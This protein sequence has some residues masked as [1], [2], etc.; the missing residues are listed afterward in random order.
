MVYD[1]SPAVDLLPEQAIGRARYMA[2]TPIRVAEPL[3]DGNERTYVLDCLES[4]WISSR[5]KYIEQF[6]DLVANFCSTQHAIATNN[7]T[8]ALHLALAALGIGPG[9]EVIVPTL[10]Y[11]AS[12]NA[13]RYCGATPV[14]VD[15]LP[16]QLTLDPGHVAARVT[17][18][19]RGILTVP[20]YGH[21]VEMNAIQAIAHRHGLFVIEDAAEALGARYHGQPVG[22]LADCTVFSFFGNKIITTGE[23]G[24]I[25][26]S[27][28]DLASRMRFLRGQAVSPDK[29][30]WHTDIGFNYRMTNVAAA[31]GC[32]QMERIDSHLERRQQVAGWY[33]HDLS[34]LQDHLLLPEAS[35]GCHHCYWMYSVILDSS[36]PIVRDELMQMM[37]AQGIETRPI[38][39][40]VHQMPPYAEPLGSYPVAESQ[41]ARG[42]S[43]PTH[44]R[45]TEADVLYVAESLAKAM[46][47]H[48]QLSPALRR[49]AA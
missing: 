8:T 41:A 28:A 23:G 46:N 31:I 27:N 7:G 25:V 12:V 33:F 4:T 34:D 47:S 38:F 35:A 1:G 30:Y 11:I 6:E 45:L 18:R 21:P 40:P 10:T 14:F 39:Y 26:T 15:S 13:I 29:N 5:G 20:L 42:I 24:M 48:A 2:R 36:A 43:L 16:H 44:G 37:A 32:G 49:H 19:T 17:S 9:D 22:S 3:L